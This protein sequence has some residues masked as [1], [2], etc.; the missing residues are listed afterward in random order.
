MKKCP[1]CAEE[2]QDEAVFCRF[3]KQD[4]T[5]AAGE[6][7]PVRPVNPV[8]V[9]YEEKTVREIV[10]RYGP[11]IIDQNIF[12]QP[13]IPTD[14]LRSALGAY[15]KDVRPETVLVLLD[16]TMRGNAKD[17]GMLTTTH[18]IAHNMMEKP[19]SVAFNSM[20]SVGLQEGLTSKLLINGI[21]VL[22]INFPSKAAMRLFTQMLNIIITAL[23]GD[24][25]MA[26]PAEAGVKTAV[27]ALKELKDLLDAGII[28][29]QEFKTKREKY[30]G[31][32]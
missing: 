27:D 28:T 20:L 18:L 5:A 2:I 9:N 24:M 11:T 23:R 14:R 22:F 8:N 15:A 30:L 7:A 19:A 10:R 12:I 1:Y 31:Q 25:T 3:C 13:N 4:L 17:G 16:N 29:E 21:P 6:A 26:K 32:L